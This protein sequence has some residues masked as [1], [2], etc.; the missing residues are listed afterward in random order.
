MKYVEVETYKEMSRK[1]ANIISAQIITKHNS[2]LGLATGSTPLGIYKQLIEWYNKGDLDFGDVIS[3]NLDEYLGLAGDH[4]QSY[5]YYM[6]N[7]LFSQVNID[8]K[9]KGSRKGAF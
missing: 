5:R 1:A 9:N 2:V 6:D 7:N 8:I 4:P 3:V